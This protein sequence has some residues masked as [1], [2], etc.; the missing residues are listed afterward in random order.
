MLRVA[1]FTGGVNVPSARFRVRQY[2]PALLRLGVSVEEMKCRFGKYPPE[3]WWARPFWGCGALMEQTP[4]VLRSFQSDVVLLQREILSTFLTLEPFTKKPRILDVDDSIY[5]YRG[6]NFARRLAQLADLIICGNECLADWFRAF[7]RNVTIIPTAVDSEKYAP[8]SVRRNPDEPK[9]IG[10]IGTRVSLKHLESI[11]DALEE[12]MREY[13]GVRLRVVCD[14]PPAFRRLPPHRVE[15]VPWAANGEVAHIQGMDIGIMPLEDSP[16]SRGKCSLKMLQYMSC[17]L[18]VVVSP[19]GMNNDILKMGTPGMSASTMRQ[20]VD[21][22]TVLLRN[23]KLRYDMGACGR[24]IVSESFSI[25]T[26]APCLAM[27][28]RGV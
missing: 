9:A 17:G 1:A 21:S 27:C 25:H 15:F 7:N 19:V 10:W 22:L 24:R 28:L 20:W 11:E 8:A 13:P 16:L 4:N 12:V 3:P 14:R 6:G 5:L 2:I 18:P 26:L 23:D